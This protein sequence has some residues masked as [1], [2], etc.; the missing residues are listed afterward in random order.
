MNCILLEPSELSGDDG[1][2]VRLTGRRMEHVTTVCRCGVGAALKVGVIGGNIGTGTI[3]RMDVSSMD[4][5]VDLGEPPPAP[6][7]LTLV[8]ALPRPKSLRKAIEAASSL[9]V[10]RL[11]IME[12]WRVE[13]SYWTS[14]VL[15]PGSLRKHLLL[16][17]EQARDTVLPEIELRRRFKPFVEDELPGIVRGKTALVAH[18]YEAQVCPFSIAGP[19]VLVIGPE[20]GFIP[21]EVDLLKQAGCTPVTIGQRILRV[22]V[23]VAAIVGRLW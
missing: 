18:P 16:G 4:L 12:S 10:K 6:L 15:A 19:A 22:E 17:L 23:A 2:T 8:L 11:F 21:Y 20:G 13:K 9:G 3:T 7:P 14:P 5:K 1:Q